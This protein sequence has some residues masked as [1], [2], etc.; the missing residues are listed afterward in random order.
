[1]S[2]YYKPDRNPNWNYGGNNWRLSRSKIDLFM[3]CPRCF[4]ID[5]R[6]GTGRPKGY[7]F[8]LNSA[9]DALLKKEFDVHRAKNTSHP[10]M[11][12]YGIDAV[13]FAHEMMDE[14]RDALRGGVTYKH[15][16]G[17]TITGGVDDIWVNSNEE[18]I[19]VDYKAT[20]K[21]GKIEALEEEWHRGYKRQLEIYQWLLRQ[22]GFKVSNT[23][24]W[25]YANADK[26][27]EAF[28]GVLE[29]EITL[30]PYEGKADWVEG[31]IQDIKKCLDGAEPPLAGDDCD[32]CQ[33]REAAGKKLQA[34]HKKTTPEKAKG[35]GTLGL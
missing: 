15:P 25:V 10:L 27:K 7:P 24:Y 11:E 13:P 8:N 18:L 21:D 3:E 32:Y 17:M 5:N 29:F 2:Q 31:V 12:T 35:S 20:S 33:Y 16:S 23:A 19:V 30:V 26:D 9:V 1:M 6:L 4:Y 14:W 34:L 22:N 28:D